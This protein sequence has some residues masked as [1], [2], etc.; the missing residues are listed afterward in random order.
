M[1]RLHPESNEAIG[2]RVAMICAAK[3]WTPAHLARQ[4][5]ITS[6]A[7]Y[8]WEK[9]TKRPSMNNALRICALTGATIEWIYRGRG[10]HHLPPELR[11]NFSPSDIAEFAS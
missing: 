9:G 10:L 5:G 8:Q 1:K 7:I 6:Q 11:D 3:G 4:I 2:K